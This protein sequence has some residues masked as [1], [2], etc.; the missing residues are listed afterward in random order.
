LL[1]IED[2]GSKRFGKGSKCVFCLLKWIG[3]NQSML[4]ISNQSQC[5]TKL[6]LNSQN[7][8]MGRGE[9]KL[10]VYKGVPGTHGKGKSGL[11]G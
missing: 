3:M 9:P 1:I 4:N 8:L 10:C 5:F 7:S 11:D 2:K 6:V